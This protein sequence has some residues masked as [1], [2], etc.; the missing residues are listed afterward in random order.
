MLHLQKEFTHSQR[1]LSG[2]NLYTEWATNRSAQASRRFCVQRKLLFFFLQ[3]MDDYATALLAA[4]AGFGHLLFQKFNKVLTLRSRWLDD[5]KC[6]IWQPISWSWLHSINCAAPCYRIVT[7][8]ANHLHFPALF[9]SVLHARI[10]TRM[11]TNTYNHEYDSQGI[12][13]FN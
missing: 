7:F 4:A 13:I 2:V 6:L 11:H 10:H 3:S 5:R 12:V 1:F 9:N 8:Q